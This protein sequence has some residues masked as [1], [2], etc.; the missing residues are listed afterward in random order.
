M[1]VLI[2]TYWIRI[3]EGWVL[4]ICILNMFLNLQLKDGFIIEN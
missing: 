2:Q 3:L 1:Q 4:L